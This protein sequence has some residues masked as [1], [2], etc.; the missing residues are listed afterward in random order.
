MLEGLDKI[1]WGSLSH[2][3][4]PAADVPETLR[5]LASGRMG[6]GEA[7]EEFWGNIWHQGTVYEATAH[8]VPF[9]LE[10]LQSSAI[11]GREW[12]LLLLASL[13]SGSSYRDVHGN[14]LLP[15]EP[16]AF[17]KGRQRELVW[18]EEA[19]RAVGEGVTLYLSL[20]ESREANVRTTAA[21]VLSCFPERREAILPTL[22]QRLSHE[23]DRDAQASLMLCLG[24]L[25][26]DDPALRGPLE[27]ALPLNADD[28]RRLAAALSLV[29]Q[30]GERAAARAVQVLRDALADPESSPEAYVFQVWDIE[31]APGVAICEALLCLGRERAVSVLADLWSAMGEPPEALAD[32]LEESE[33]P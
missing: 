12:L 18:V 25:G 4:G 16:E 15:E 21:H 9:L 7:V 17:E 30:D 26:D 20:L 23:R 1:S 32:L 28:P 22:R 8:T 29:R 19:H 11:E 10:L 2:A 3:Y 6:A 5:A 27:D 24:V 31:A 13:A 14:R 33:A